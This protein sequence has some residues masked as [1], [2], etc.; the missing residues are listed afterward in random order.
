M[1]YFYKNGALICT[2]F[3]C[4][5]NKKHTLMHNNWM[6]VSS[7]LLVAESLDP[8]DSIDVEACT[9]CAHVREIKK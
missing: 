2:C 4:Q 1:N 8:N 5:R 3:F 6:R 9:T 7:V